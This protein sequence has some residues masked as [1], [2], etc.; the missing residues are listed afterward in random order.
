MTSVSAFTSSTGSVR[1]CTIERDKYD[2]GSY[3][4]SGPIRLS[5]SAI[6]FLRCR[7]AVADGG[8]DYPFTGAETRESS[9]LSVFDASPTFIDCTFADS[10]GGPHGGMLSTWGDADPTFINCT[11]RAT[12][13]E[14]G[15]SVVYAGD[16]SHPT[17]INCEMTGSTI[18]DPGA[19]LGGVITT[20]AAA[21]PDAHVDLL[22]CTIWGHDVP[23]PAL[24]GN[25][26]ATNCLV[27]GLAPLDPLFKRPPDA[28]AD[29]WFDDRSTVDVDESADN[30]YG[31][32]RLARGSPA[33]DAGDTAALPPD[34]F[35]LD[36]D[37]D[38]A[39]P[40]PVDLA[41][42]PRVVNDPDTPDTGPGPAPVVDLGAY[43]F[44]AP[45]CL[46]DLDANGLLN[47]DDIAAF[48][49]AFLAGDLLADLDANGTLNLDD[50][51]AFAQG[52]LAGCP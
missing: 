30:D 25:V 50:V 32:L 49:G 40:L 46:A 45:P 43:E 11:F 29:G 37:G 48:A 8:R 21:Y 24:V 35:D 47:L 1:D 12:A 39:E 22:N 42:D 26:A 16:T 6:D 13:A 38:T 7:I 23:G 2:Y 41:G 36:G 9:G 20:D 14:E 33:I 44:Q 17:F 52:F 51:A 27:Q 28:G 31:D 18:T 34:A 19:T 3:V 5:E 10:H 15:G 4:P